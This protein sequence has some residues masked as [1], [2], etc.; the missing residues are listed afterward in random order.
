MLVSLVDY[1][2]TEYEY[3]VSLGPKTCDLDLRAFKWHLQITEKASPE[4]LSEFSTKITKTGTAQYK[5][6]L[7]FQEEPKEQSLLLFTLEH[8]SAIAKVPTSA[9]KLLE[10]VE[11]PKA[12]VAGVLSGSLVSAAAIGATSALWS[13]ISF[14][15]FV[16]Y[17]I[18]INIKFP[19]HVEYFLSILSASF[20]DYLP[21]PL[22]RMTDDMY[23]DL[24]D[25]NGQIPYEYKPPS[26]FREYDVI[27]FFIKDSGE[28]IATNLLLL[29]I[30]ALVLLIKNFKKFNQNKYLKKIKVALK[31]NI[32]ARTF[33]ENGIPLSLS[34]FLQLRIMQ[35]NNL[36]LAFCSSLC[37]IAIFLVLAKLG[38]LIK[39]LAKRDNKHLEQ[40][41]VR[42]MYGTLYEGVLLQGWAKYYQILILLRGI[43]FVC[44]LVFCGE[45]PLFQIIFEIFCR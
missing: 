18:F 41:F 24:L 37:I 7:T 42:R 31:W 25:E 27:S 44:V 10:E 3:Q 1:D 11:T 28:I 30:L 39:I 20:W 4:V 40:S 8:L 19:S 17:F 32:I 45:A 16:G 35:F 23:K 29:F 12:V 6:H 36:Y 5:V 33:L 38:F 9:T 22:A 13:I 2:N 26:K 43:S 15:Q 14:Q 34:I 21:N